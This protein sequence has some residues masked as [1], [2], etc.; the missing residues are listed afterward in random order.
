MTN[1]MA[2]NICKDLSSGLFSIREI[3]NKY[4][5]PYSRVN[6]IKQRKTWTKVSKDYNFDNYNKFNN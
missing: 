6:D 4:N 1:E 3:A 5:I 2:I